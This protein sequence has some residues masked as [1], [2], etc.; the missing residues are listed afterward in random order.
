[1]DVSEHFH[2]IFRRANCPAARAKF[3][4][5]LFGIFSEEIV[6]L[7]AHDHRAPYR[8]VGRPTIKTHGSNRGH[9]L[10]F[11]LRESATGKLFVAEMK[12]EIEYQNFRYFVLENVEQLAHHSKPAFDAFLRAAVSPADQEVYVAGN[13]VRIDGAIL[14]WGSA[15][16][17]GRRAVIQGKGFH[18]VLTIADIRRQLSSWNHDGYRNLLSQRQEWCNDLFSGLL[19]LKVAAEIP[20]VSVQRGTR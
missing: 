4:S 5:R 3:L 9:T 14:I 6:S 10:D 15:T 19:E 7:W 12:C 13:R 16:Q 2:S 18:D 11:T 17:E 8:S 1:M 20:V